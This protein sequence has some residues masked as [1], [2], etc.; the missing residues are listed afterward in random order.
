MNFN[1][2][3]RQFIFILISYL[4]PS[5][6]LRQEDERLIQLVKVRHSGLQRQLLIISKT[7]PLS[8][9]AKLNKLKFYFTLSLACGHKL[10]FGRVPSFPKEFEKVIL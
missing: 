9:P 8:D 6:G 10:G 7:T 1:E 2:S 4:D 5:N 3:G